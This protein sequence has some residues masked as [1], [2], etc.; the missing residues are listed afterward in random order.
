ML[1]YHPER[2]LV[3]AEVEHSFLTEEICERFAD[4][5]Q[6]VI[7]N[8]SDQNLAEAAETLKTSLTKGKKNPSSQ[9][10]QRKR[11]QK[12]SWLVQGLHML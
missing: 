4:V 2:I 8:D 3:D 9:A 12:L 11:S 7:Q 5:P 6:Y 1:N 10:I